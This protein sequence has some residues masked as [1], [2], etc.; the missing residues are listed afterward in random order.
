MSA[1]HNNFILYGNNGLSNR[2]FQI[3]DLSF[4][5]GANQDLQEIA[6]SR[7]GGS[8]VV[9][10][11]NTSKT[12][13]I[14][15]GVTYT[16]TTQREDSVLYMTSKVNEIFSYS[17]RYLRTVPRDRV[18]ELNG[19]QSVSGWGTTGDGSSL[20]VDTRE[21]AYG[22]AS[23][24][25]N[26]TVST[27]SVEYTCTIPARDLTT[28]ANSGNFETWVWIDDSYFI[29]SIDIRIGSNASNYYRASLTTNYEGRPFEN[30]W[31]FISASWGNDVE[32]LKLT[33]VGTVNNASITHLRV[34]IKYPVS[35]TNFKAKLGGFFHV[36]EDFVRNYPCYLDGGISW[37]PDWAFTAGNSKNDFSAT[38]LNY[39]GYSTATHAITL[40]NLTG[41]TTASSTQIVDLKGNLEPALTNTFTLNT[42]TNLNDLR[43][44]NLNTN[45]IIRWTNNWGA[46][47]V[48][49]FDKL[50]SIVTRN[51]APQDFI[52]QLPTAKLGINRIQMQVVTTSTQQIAQNIFNSALAIR[53]PGGILPPP[54]IVSGYQTFL[55][56]IAG[57]ITSV[58]VYIR[59][60]TGM[61]LSITADNASTP[62]TVLATHT[63]LGGAGNGA[64]VVIPTDLVVANATTFGLLIESSD[65]FLGGEWFFNSAGGYAG[66]VGRS[67]SNTTFS[68]I[69][70][71]AFRVNI[72]PTPAT[73]IDW[74]CNYKPLH[75]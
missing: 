12:I 67:R 63:I 8:S 48:V 30:G 27:G 13:S 10:I 25:S 45:E 50:N 56:P 32:G 57:T 46:N 37:Q 1:N 29:T 39:T 14:T 62:S 52:G 9:R 17:N 28:V 34:S 55:T 16:N 66:G 43:F 53:R 68:T 15:G 23:I 5:D 2:R 61:T 74:N 4:L 38:L 42:V 35:A 31:N 44:S 20:L 51:N 41:I 60:N 19:T 6:L 58:E 24:A 75:A 22:Q 18:A 54:V 40:F 49:R 73:N 36:Q 26:V 70:D 7:A 47:D 11:R 21:F 59:Y 69:G 33:Q 71:M 64:W 65:V 72:Q 3:K